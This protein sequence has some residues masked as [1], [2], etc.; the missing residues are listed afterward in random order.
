MRNRYWTNQVKRITRLLGRKP[1]SVLDVG[2][3]TGDFLMHWES[4]IA[5]EGIELSKRSAQIARKRGLV[6]HDDFFENINFDKRYEVVTCYAFIEH[7]VN[8]LVSLDKLARIVAPEGILII[9]I[10]AYQSFKRWIIDT[11][12]SIRWHMYSPPE[13]LSFYSKKFLDTYFS[14]KGF[15]LKYRY[16]T[17]GG[18]FNPFKNIPFANSVF[19]KVMHLLDEYIPINKLPIFDHMYSYYI[20]SQQNLKSESMR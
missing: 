9:M 2:C 4:S 6:V 8:P 13:H 18:M 7:L 20:L 12:T 14:N 19:A 16:W 3:G 10:P 1:A 5:V 11:F 17:S 15:N